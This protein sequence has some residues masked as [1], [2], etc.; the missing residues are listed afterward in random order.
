MPDPNTHADDMKSP[1]Q[2]CY[3]P[4]FWWLNPWREAKAWRRRAESGYASATRSAEKYV[5]LAG[6]KL[7]IEADNLAARQALSKHFGEVIKS[8]LTL[9]ANCREAGLIYG[10]FVRS[11]ANLSDEVARLRK[12]I[13]AAAAETPI[14][15]F[16]GHG[17]ANWMKN[18]AHVI[19]QLRKELH[20]ARTD[21]AE[22]DKHHAEEHAANVRLQQELAE[23]QSRLNAAIFAFKKPAK[24]KPKAKKKG[25]RK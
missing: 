19:V 2:T 16:D 22:A 6:Q 23:V 9:T 21:K 14:Y 11:H 1:V 4:P 3:M 7:Q 24:R 8:P 20:D 12:E 5:R 15:C 17:P 25:G 10:H 18:A 13:D